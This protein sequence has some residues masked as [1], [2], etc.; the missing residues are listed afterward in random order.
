MSKEKKQALIT[1]A[2]MQSDALKR[3]GRWRTMALFIAALGIVFAWLGFSRQ[4][5]SLIIGILGICMTVISF[6]LAMVFNIGIR[7]GNENVRK[8]LD[9]AEKE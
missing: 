7:N 4:P 8:I 9:A 2:K 5:K 1:E 6:L 3:I